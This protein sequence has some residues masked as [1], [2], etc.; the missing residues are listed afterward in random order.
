M[1]SLIQLVDYILKKKQ[2]INNSNFNFV[3]CGCWKGTSTYLVSSLL[4]EN[5]FRGKFYVFDSFEGGLSKLSDEDFIKSQSIINIKKNKNIRENFASS[6]KEVKKVL[7]K[8]EFVEI[9]KGW[10]PERFNEVSSKKFNFIHIDVDLYKPTLDSIKFFFPRLEK[11]G[12]MICDD[13]NSTDFPGAK[14]AWDEYFS[15]KK[16]DLSFYF[17]GPFG[18]VFLIK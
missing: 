8:F 4:K 12:I 3:E 17:E 2:F 14:K 18:S 13:Y 10:I 11:N 9:F 15:L 16:D 7:N 1:Y 5:N 6:E